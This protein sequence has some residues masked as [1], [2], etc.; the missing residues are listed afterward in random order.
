M[1]KFKAI[2]KDIGIGAGIFLGFFV[3][4]FLVLF[5]G[6]NIFYE[7]NL[8]PEHIALIIVFAG[9]LTAGTTTT[10]LYFI[11]RKKNKHKF[12]SAVGAKIIFFL[13][14]F[15][16]FIN[17]FK[18]EIILTTEAAQKLVE[19]EWTIFSIAM[20]AFVFWH[21][22][23]SKFLENPPKNTGF[24]DERIN[25]IIDKQLFYKD[26]VNF[27]YNLTLLTTSML[28][29]VFATPSIFVTGKINFLNQFAL[30]FNITIVTNALMVIFYDIARP[31]TS[32][33]IIKKNNKMTDEEIDDEIALS[34][35][36]E[37]AKDALKDGDKKLTQEE[38]T[39]LFKQILQEAKKKNTNEGLTQPQLTEKE[40][41]N[42]LNA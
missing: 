2:L 18:S 42:E 8:I 34:L 33:F 14:L 22:I 37:T 20:T 9:A 36:E 39:T 15:Q 16:G 41:T 7:K 11:K 25:A 3:A 28:C 1:I 40:Q 29:L 6:V 13:F 5:L 19:M 4:A 32:Q 23:V 31:L 21:V 35:L 38:I 26:T 24:G 30:L 17:A 27:S 12:F 10:I